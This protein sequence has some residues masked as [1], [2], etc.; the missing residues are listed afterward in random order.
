MARLRG[1]YPHFGQMS[2]AEERAREAWWREHMASIA[3]AER[4][5]RELAVAVDAENLPAV[6]RTQELLAEAVDKL[7]DAH[8]GPTMPEPEEPEEER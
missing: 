8:Y 1:G 3:T 6:E 4:L 5:L 2:N 7:R